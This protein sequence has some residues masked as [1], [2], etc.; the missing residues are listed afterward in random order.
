MATIHADELQPGDVVVYDGQ[1]HRVARVDRRDG[2]SWP[3]AAD[4]TGWAIALDHELIDI[5][6]SDGPGVNCQSAPRSCRRACS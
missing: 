5:L 6:S 2:W 1:H 4:D 3:I